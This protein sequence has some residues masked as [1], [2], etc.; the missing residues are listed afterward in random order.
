VEIFDHDNTVAIVSGS[1]EET[2]GTKEIIQ[3]KTI[4]QIVEETNRAISGDA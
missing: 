3:E 2:P 1:H 4:E